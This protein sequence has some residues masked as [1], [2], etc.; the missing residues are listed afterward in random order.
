MYP[1]LVYLKYISKLGKNSDRTMASKLNKTVEIKGNN[2]KIVLT[3]N[4]V[5]II[6]SCEGWINKL[7]SAK[8]PEPNPINK[9]FVIY[10]KKIENTARIINIA[11]RFIIQI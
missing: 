4:S 10:P 6:I 8:N 3:A 5:S 1:N 7:L 11:V 9:S 2:L